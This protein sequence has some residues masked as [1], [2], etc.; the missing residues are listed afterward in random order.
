MAGRMVR[1]QYQQQTNLLP[2]AL[3]VGS[4]SAED[5]Q[6][7]LQW[8]TTM[9]DTAQAEI[10]RAD[11]DPAQARGRQ[12]AAGGAGEAGGGG[13]QGRGGEPGAA[14]DPGGAGGDRAGERGRAAPSAARSSGPRR[15]TTWPTTRPATPADPGARVGGAP[16]RGPDRQGQGRG[17]ARRPRPRRGL[18]PRPPRRGSARPREPRRKPSAPSSAPRRP[19]GRRPGPKRP[20]W[21]GR[22]RRG[23]GPPSGEPGGPPGPAVLS[24]RATAS[25]TRC[26]RRSPPRTGCGSIRCCT[27][28]SC[29][30]APTSAPAAAPRSA[31]RTRGGSRRSYY[32]AGYGNRLMI[33]HGYV[34]A[35]YVTTGYNHA[36]RY[37]VGVG[38]RVSKGQVIGYV[39][40]TGYSTGCHLHL[41]VW[42]ER[43]GHQPDA[44]VLTV[45]PENVTP[46]GP[47][48]ATRRAAVKRASQIQAQARAVTA[49]WPVSGEDRGHGEG[50]GPQA[51]RAEPQG[52][53]RLPHP[54]HLR[55]WDRAQRYR[56]EVAAGGA[57]QPGGRVRHRGRRGGVAA[58]GPHPRVQPRHLDQPHRPA[59]PQAAAA[60]ARR[61]TRSSASWTTRARPWCRWPSTSPTGTPRSRSPWPPA[62]GSTTSGRPSPPASPSREARAGAGRPEPGRR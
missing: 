29:T 48:G 49:S 13:P 57:G 24:G 25:P 61:S 22:P 53:A 56:G 42:L 12:G 35:S 36:I 10:D 54:R 58:R 34:A 2:V 50:E 15:P 27:T 51:G 30:T 18:G 43:P 31:P 3:L 52:S 17:R 14:Q 47:R 8:S 23:L 55:G 28:G 40:S 46:V 26:R 33:D 5:L 38:Q 32:N 45:L 21:R 6:T 20:R 9:F 44:L 7:R 37:T 4:Q 59:H 41:M 11:R 62:S 60:T 39:G 1:D 16:D 19:A